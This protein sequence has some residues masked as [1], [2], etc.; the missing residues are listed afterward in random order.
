MH[1]IW[2]PVYCFTGFLEE[3]KCYLYAFFSY[4]ISTVSHCTCAV[5]ITHCL[6]RL[7]LSERFF[8][9]SL[10]TIFS[11]SSSI[12]IDHVCSRCKQVSCPARAYLLTVSIYSRTPLPNSHLHFWKV[13]MC[14]DHQ[15]HRC[16]LDQYL[17]RARQFDGWG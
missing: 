4:N 3:K 13:I 11:H 15:P 12:S 9:G 14:L 2:F 5:N 16:R 17:L 7:V 6:Q 8:S 1:E 10:R